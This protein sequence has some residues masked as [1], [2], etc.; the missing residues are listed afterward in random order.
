MPMHPVF[1]CAG[2]DAKGAALLI[3][4]MD[5]WSMN[6]S[7]EDCAISSF[8]TSPSLRIVISTRVERGLFG[9]T[10]RSCSDCEF[11]L[12]LTVP[13]SFCTYRST[14]SPV[15]WV[16][17]ESVAGHEGVPR[18]SAIADRLAKWQKPALQESRVECAGSFL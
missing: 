16:L 15:S 13:T 1:S 7:P 6:L 9:R 11:Q 4:S 10:P 8:L 14:S 5:A 2:S 18:S 12:C 3:A 17:S